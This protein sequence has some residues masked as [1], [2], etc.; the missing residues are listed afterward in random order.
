MKSTEWPSQNVRETFLA[1]FEKKKGHR[2]LPSFPLI[3]VNDPTLLLIA[4]GMAPFK[5]EFAGIAKPASPRITTCQKCLRAD[6]ILQVGHTSRHH[7]FFEM[8]GN[9]SFGDYFKEEAILWAWELLTEDYKMPKEKLFVS[10]HT[11]DDEAYGIWEK[12]I[13]IPTNKLFRLAD[14]FWGPVGPAGPCGPDSEIYYDRGIQNGCGKSDCKPSCENRNPSGESCDRFIEIWNLVFTMYHKD[15]SGKLHELPKKNIDTGAGLERITMVLQGKKSPFETELFLPMIEALIPGGP[16]NRGETVASRIVA[17]HLRA[18]VFMLADGVI[19]SNEGR[20]YVLRRILRRA[21]LYRQ[22]FSKAPT[23]SKLAPAVIG[24]MKPIYPELEKEKALILS[25]IETAENE[26]L[27]TLKIGNEFL[28]AEAASLKPAAGKTIVPGSLLFRLHDE[29]GFPFELAKDLLESKGYGVDEEGFKR[30]MNK[31]RERSRTGGPMTGA[32]KNTATAVTAHS[33]TLFLGYEKIESPVEIIELIKD[34]KPVPALAVNEEGIAVFNRSPFY[35]EGGG[36]VGDTGKLKGAGVLAAIS[37]TQK[38][39]GG[40]IFHY[41]SVS[42]GSLKKG[43]TVDASVDKERREEIR[44]HHT[45]THLLHA[46][47]RSILGTHVQQA[48]S[49][50]NDQYLRLDFS[51]PQSLSDAELSTIERLVNEKIMANI[52]LRVTVT[53]QEEAKKEGAIAFF[54]EK[55]GEK[56]R[57]VDVPE[58]SKELCGGTHVHRT[59]DVGPFSITRESAIAKGVRRIEAKAGR[60]GIDY[61]SSLQTLKQSLVK[62]LKAEE[63]EVVSSVESIL[64]D[65]QEKEKEIFRLREESARMKALRLAEKATKID[66][67]MCVFESVSGARKEELRVMADQLKHDLKSGIVLLISSENGKLSLVSAVTP[68]IISRGFSAV[69]FIKSACLAVGGGGGGRDDLAE[70]GGKDPSKIDQ[71]FK[72]AIEVIRQKGKGSS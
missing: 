5:A 17:D 7:T 23:L 50:V 29:R 64:N 42:N 35:P 62:R 8:L 68:D 51:H 15:E 69:S 52:E 21:S 2:R 57:I 46:A 39:E 14:N 54:G 31:Q 22:N 49:F 61:H 41:V 63:S 12:K 47:L 71:A 24:T 30:E 4:A 58:F 27:Q 1:F 60:S 43:M 25:S 6:D 72:N 18:V 20:G 13:G 67:I 28:L 10:V 33:P 9:F 34:E 3:P 40:I 37:D 44:K 59:G 56:V 36:Q 45:A 26:F 53:S 16:K 65:R 32:M 38:N 11:D 70:A 55:Y 66:G 48:G 19:P